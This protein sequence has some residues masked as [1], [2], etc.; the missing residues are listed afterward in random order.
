MKKGQSDMNTSGIPDQ[1]AARSVSK[2]ANKI[3][4]KMDTFRTQG[5]FSGAE[6]RVLHYLLAQKGDVYQKDIEEEYSIRPATASQLLKKMEQDGLI[7]RESVP[8][9]NR[10][11]KIIVTDKAKENQE[12][13]VKNILELENGLTCGIDSARLSVFFEVMDQMMENMN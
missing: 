9:D 1:S 7:R 5:S 6:G 2:L 13:V 12:L 11:K 3:R 8:H 10:L 4:R